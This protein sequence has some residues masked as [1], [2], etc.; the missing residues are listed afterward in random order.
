MIRTVIRTS[1]DIFHAR[2]TGN[3]HIRAFQKLSSS[4]TP[5]IHKKK[6]PSPIRRDG[7]NT[8]LFGNK[9]YDQH[10]HLLFM[11]Y[12]HDSRSLDVTARFQVNRQSF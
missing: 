6:D 2:Y 11:I 9:Q 8:P 12:S 4:Q 3:C 1:L 10:H 7:S 5:L